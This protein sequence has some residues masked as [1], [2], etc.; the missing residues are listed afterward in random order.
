MEK[1]S[2][3]LA[4]FAFALLSF[5]FNPFGSVSV[6]AIVFSS[7]GLKERRHLGNH[8]FCVGGL[9]GGI[10][11]LVLDIVDIFLCNS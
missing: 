4:G 6:L 10:V 7:I 8:G 5:A 9:C 3:S 2:F 11:S 1:Q